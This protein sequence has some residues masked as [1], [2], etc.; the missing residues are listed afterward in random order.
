MAGGELGRVCVQ[1]T[2]HSTKYEKKIDEERNVFDQCS[3]SLKKSDDLGT[4][5][6]SSR[7]PTFFHFKNP[8]EQISQS[9]NLR[10]TIDV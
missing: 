2:I 10:G 8:N 5:Q 9:N 6:S 3:R 7:G 1:T 4:H